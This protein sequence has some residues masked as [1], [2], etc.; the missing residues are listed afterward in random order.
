MAKH[1]E[2]CG[3]ALCLLV[4]NEV[5]QVAALYEGLKLIDIYP[6][7]CK[8]NDYLGVFCLLASVSLKPLEEHVVL[9]KDGI[10]Y[11]LIPLVKNRVIVLVL[12]KYINPSL[13]ADYA[14]NT[15]RCFKELISK[16][17]ELTVT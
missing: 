10:W 5:V 12:N 2:Y 4:D 17:K 16:S 9:K 1:T 6:P 13:A 7:T 3:S 11:V 8:L 14:E 15:I